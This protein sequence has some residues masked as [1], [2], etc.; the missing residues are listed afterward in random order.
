MATFKRLKTDFIEERVRKIRDTR[1][2]KFKSKY[3]RFVL[4]F[5]IITLWY[6]FLILGMQ[7]DTGTNASFNDIEKVNSAIGTAV[8]SWDRSSLQFLD[9]NTGY[10]FCNSEIKGFYSDLANIG[11]Q[12]MGSTVFE[13]YYVQSGEGPNKNNPGV[14]IFTGEVPALKSGQTIRLLYTPDLSTLKPGKYKFKAY[15]RP[16]HGDPQGKDPSSG[17]KELW[18]QEIEVAL[19]DIEECKK[20]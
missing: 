8:W 2:R 10:G 9:E 1:V 13:I 15:Q 17:L 12:M 3:K 18:G 16:G 4:A 11:E 19:T 6:G 20:K 14:K 5:K 7:W